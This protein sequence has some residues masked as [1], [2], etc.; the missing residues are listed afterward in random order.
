MSIRRGTV[1]VPRTTAE[2]RSRPWLAACCGAL[3]WI[4]RDRGGVI[5]TMDGGGGGGERA[6]PEKQGQSNTM[7]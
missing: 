6:L 4:D 1:F 2:E 5:R 3:P 7:S